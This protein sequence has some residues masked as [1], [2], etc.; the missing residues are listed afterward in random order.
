MTL[1]YKTGTIVPFE[2]LV[3]LTFSVVRRLHEDERTIRDGADE[4]ILFEGERTFVLLH[5]QDCCEEVYLEDC[6]GNLNDL[7][8]TEIVSAVRAVS[9]ALETSKCGDT[10]TWS[11]YHLRTHL[12]DVTLRFVGSSNGYY[13]ETVDLYEITPTTQENIQ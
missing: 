13:S 7:V 10:E 3:G 4:G 9:E 5:A 11:F 8:N 2:T 12:G 6:N 1:Q